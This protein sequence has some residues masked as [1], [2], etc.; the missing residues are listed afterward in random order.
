M[1]QSILVD[2]PRGREVYIFVDALDDCDPG[3]AR[4]QAF[5]WRAVTQQADENGVRLKVLLASR[6]FPLITLNSCPEIVVDR[7]NHRD[8]ATYVNHRFSLAISA[9]ERRWKELRDA[10]L[11]KARGVFLWVVLVVDELLQLWDEGWGFDVLLKCVRFLPP[12]LHKLFIRLLATMTSDERKLAQRLLEWAILSTRPLRIHEWHHI[13]EFI[14]QPAPSSLASC[15]KEDGQLERKIRSLS[16]GL[17]EIVATPAASSD[18]GTESSVSVRVGAGS[19][20][21][22]H[23]GSRSVQVVHESVRQFFIEFSK[24]GGGMQTK[25]VGNC[26]LSIMEVCLDYIG[27]VE[28]NALIDARDVAWRND[29]SAVVNRRSVGSSR[30]DDA[31][32]NSLVLIGLAEGIAHHGGW[33][34]SGQFRRTKEWVVDMSGDETTKEPEANTGIQFSAIPLSPPPS[35]RRQPSIESQ[36]LEAHPALLMYAVHELFTHAQLAHKFGADLGRFLNRLSMG[37]T[38]ER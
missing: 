29:T 33:R 23:S 15:S 12:E 35:I 32:D 14:K 8:I 4:S 31:N 3:H 5:F 19:M 21:S 18:D 2:Q 34:A 6:N 26:H 38:W 28:L 27:I 25:S 24:Q 17:L 20:D 37:P 9:K 22:N 1:T 13:L 30:L 10:I 7:H 16:R 36:T 11:Q